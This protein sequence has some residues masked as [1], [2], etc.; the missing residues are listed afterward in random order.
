MAKRRLDKK[1]LDKISDKLGI[2]QRAVN[3]KVSK[4][5]RKLGISSE[6]ALVLLAR[7]LGI[8]T[9]TYQRKLNPSIQTEVREALPLMFAKTVKNAKK[10]AIPVKSTRAQRSISPV[11]LAIEYLIED[12]ELSDRCKD[13]LLARSHFDRPINQAT[14]VLEDRIR[15]KSK[16]PTSMVGV[17][18]VNYA[19]NED[20][21]KTVL[22]IS[23]DADEQRGFTSIIRGVVPA[24]RNRT[25]HHV[26]NSFTQKEALRVCAFIDVLL[27]I[28]DNSIKKK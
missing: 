7:E 9:A 1:L 3:V 24:F 28:V 6:A 11:K 5:A 12:K 17:K 25:H 21:S 27:R 20:L 19:F 26:I 10:K 15:K 8:G 2:Q 14:L 18:L 23:G 22:Q 4:K 13:I 16:P